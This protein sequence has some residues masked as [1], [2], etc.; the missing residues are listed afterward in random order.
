M[1]QKTRAIVVATQKKPY[2]EIKSRLNRHCLLLL[3]FECVFFLYLVFK[4]EL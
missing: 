4:P 3:I 2:E 1:T